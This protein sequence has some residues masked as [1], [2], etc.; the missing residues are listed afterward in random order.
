MDNTLKDLI[1]RYIVKRGRKGATVYA[2]K[3]L[4]QFQMELFEFYRLYCPTKHVDISINIKNFDWE[5]YLLKVCMGFGRSICCLHCM[6]NFSWWFFVF[7][8]RWVGVYMCLGFLWGCFIN[9]VFAAWL[10]V[11]L[12]CLCCICSTFAYS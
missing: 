1:I 12:S 11:S 6:P 2:L 10:L 9:L 5:I 7:V 3:T 8:V 4:D